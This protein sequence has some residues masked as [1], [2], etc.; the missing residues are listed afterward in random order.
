MCANINQHFYFSQTTTFSH[1]GLDCVNNLYLQYLQISKELL[2]KYTN[3]VNN[4]L[5]QMFLTIE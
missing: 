1:K 2:L 3:K 4:Y 5:Y